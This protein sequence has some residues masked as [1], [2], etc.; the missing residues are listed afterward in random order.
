M[1]IRRLLSALFLTSM[2]GICIAIAGDPPAW[3]PLAIGTGLAPRLLAPAPGSDPRMLLWSGLVHRSTDWGSHWEFVPARFQGLRSVTSL[4]T[5]AFD[6]SN[7]DV[8]WATIGDRVF[9]SI[10]FGATWQRWGVPVPGA[11]IRAFVPGGPAAIAWVGSAGGPGRGIYRTS[12]G[13]ASWT[14]RRAG[15]PDADINGLAVDPAD[16]NLIVAG[17]SSGIARTTDG[18]ASWAL[19][20]PGPAAATLEWD[21]SGT[22]IVV[23][24]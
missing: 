13:G 18:G 9:R 5:L 22:T 10:D 11:R 6:P 14:P 8:A 1:G 24:F 7:A 17:T 21:A 19:T 20:R 12:D 23:E 15:L 2:L 16:A 4:E 3:R